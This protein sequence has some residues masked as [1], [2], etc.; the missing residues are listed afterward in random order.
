M[1]FP[2]GSDYNESACNVRD[3]GL[4][5]GSGI[6]LGEG[7]G[8]PL[9]YSCLENP[10][11]RAAWRATVHGIAKNWTSWS[12]WRTCIHVMHNKQLYQVTVFR[13]WGIERLLAYWSQIHTDALFSFTCLPQLFL[14]ENFHPKASENLLTYASSSGASKVS[15]P[16]RCLKPRITDT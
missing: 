11:D 15:S 7:N 2:G 14:S 16:I 10:M 13:Y 6:S 8:N 3:Q 4:I 9:Q 5:F 1:G 12:D